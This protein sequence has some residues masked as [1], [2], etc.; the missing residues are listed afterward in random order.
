MT[1]PAIV[2][3]AGA[4][5]TPAAYSKFASG[6]KA[7]GHEVHIPSLPSMNGARPPN[8]DLNTD[9][10]LIRGYVE[11]LTEAG[12]NVV[13]IMHSYGGQV[14]T[15]ALVGLGAE[16][17][18]KDG[19]PGGVIRLVYVCAYALTEGRSMF[20]M[21]KDMGHEALMPI[22]FD[23]A[24]DETVLD[25][26]PKNL[27]VGP[28]LSEEELEAYVAGLKRWNGKPIY[29]PIGQCA[30]REIPVSYVYTLNDMTVP[31]DYQKVM[32][33][34]MRAEGRQVKTLEVDTGHC[35]TI[36]RTQELVDMVHGIVTAA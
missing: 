10:T 4:W 8:A 36:T 9:I 11:S 29:Q 5:H 16:T 19:L 21:V 13:V 23:F 28:G 6:L 26:D 18:Q 31:W 3:V 17:R 2:F 34:N 25:R 27:L 24:E 30:W 12:R 15:D 1:T 33:E 22:A 7:L 32:V 14:G 20:D 35:P